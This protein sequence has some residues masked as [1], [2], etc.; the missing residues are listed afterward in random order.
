MHELNINLKPTIVNSPKPIYKG[1]LRPKEYSTKIPLSH[2]KPTYEDFELY[3]L[4]IDR[5]I[6][7]L[8]PQPQQKHSVIQEYS[9][10]VISESSQSWRNPAVSP[11]KKKQLDSNLE[12]KKRT[13]VLGTEGVPIEP[14][15]PR[16]IDLRFQRE[17]IGP[18]NFN[19]DC[20]PFRNVYNYESQ[21]DQSGAI[22]YLFS[23][24]KE[25]LKLIFPEELEYKERS[26]FITILDKIIYYLFG[27]DKYQFFE[28]SLRR[29]RFYSLPT[30]ALTQ[31]FNH[32]EDE[33]DDFFIDEEEDISADNFYSGNDSW[34][35]M[36]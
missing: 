24:P 27:I 35:E 32:P 33:N 23:D 22:E 15:Q 25:G 5:Q 29:D 26:E 1:N 3:D 4:Y 20:G 12:S 16:I 14:D 30:V 19:F 13:K 34:G 6:E 28:M 9:P 7:E 18:R 31:P 2:I 11:L 36:A 10:S 21:Y 17:I 8:Q